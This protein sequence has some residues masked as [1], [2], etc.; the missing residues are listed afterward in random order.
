MRSGGQATGFIMVKFAPTNLWPSFVVEIAETTDVLASPIRSRVSINGPSVGRGL[1]R[2]AWKKLGQYALRDELKGHPSIVQWPVGTLDVTVW[3]GRGPSRVTQLMIHR[4]KIW[5]SSRTGM[6]FIT[7]R[8]DWP[9]ITRP[10]KRAKRLP[11]RGPSEGR[12][13]A[14]VE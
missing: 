6:P 3:T 9:L 1:R 4:S 14:S 11:A 10:M 12:F 7:S 8:L 5:K 2:G 13:G